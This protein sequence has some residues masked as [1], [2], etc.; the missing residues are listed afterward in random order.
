MSFGRLCHLLAPDW[1]TMTPEQRQP[2]KAMYQQDRA[3]YIQELGTLSRDKQKIL[4]DNRRLR[5]EQK[6]KQGRPRVALSS[7]MMFA[8]HERA[9]VT[10]QFPHF[11]FQEV[12]R[13]LGRRWQSLS[14]DQRQEIEQQIA[15]DRQR[16]AHELEN[17]HRQKKEALETEERK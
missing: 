2:F 5:R 16:Y 9:K 7:Y 6:I 8:S 11:S 10:A 17:W 13:E 14:M 12:G 4:R 15:L 3:R 1:R